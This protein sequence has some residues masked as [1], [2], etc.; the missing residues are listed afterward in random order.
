M[1][2]GRENQLTKQ[3]GEYL[4]SA[5]LCRRG[6]VATTF[7]GNIPEFDMLAVNGSNE[8]IPLQVKTR[9]LAT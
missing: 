4:V 3:V 2:K 7:T 1:T 5:E 6:F 9:H 8:T